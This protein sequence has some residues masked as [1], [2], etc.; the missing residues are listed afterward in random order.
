MTGLTRQFDELLKSFDHNIQTLEQASRGG[1]IQ[2]FGF[3]PIEGMKISQTQ[4]VIISLEIKRSA[5]AGI[6]FAYELEKVRLRINR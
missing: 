3:D 4:M 6:G 5:N 1:R 2:M